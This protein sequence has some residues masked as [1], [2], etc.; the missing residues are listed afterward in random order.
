MRAPQSLLNISQF[1]NLS[2]RVESRGCCTDLGQGLSIKESTMG[3]VFI[4]GFCPWVTKSFNNCLHP[5]SGRLE[6]SPLYPLVTLWVL[7]QSGQPTFRSDEVNRVMTNQILGPWS[8]SLLK[9]ENILSLSF[10]APFFPQP[11][12]GQSTNDLESAFKPRFPLQFILLLFPYLWKQHQNEQLQLLLF[13]SS[14]P[15]G[16]SNTTHNY[17]SSHRSKVSGKV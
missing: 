1:L 7:A 16:Q 17:Y 8:L 12:T 11:S 6:V 3:R 15:A 10:L 13:L 4:L 5:I 14:R 2:P 9:W